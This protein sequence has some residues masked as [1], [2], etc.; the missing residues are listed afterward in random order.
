MFSRELPVGLKFASK[1]KRFRENELEVAEVLLAL[2]MRIQTATESKIMALLPVE[3]VCASLELP[4]T[5]NQAPS[6]F[7]K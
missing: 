4:D 1:A 5:F 6:V 2:A 7:R 3:N